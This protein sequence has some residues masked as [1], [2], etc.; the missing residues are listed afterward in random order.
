MSKVISMFEDSEDIYEG[1]E[2]VVGTLQVAAGQ[3]GDHEHKLGEVA[4]QK[5]IQEMDIHY[6][7]GFS[8]PHFSRC[9]DR[10]SEEIQEL[11][12]VLIQDNKFSDVK[13][14]T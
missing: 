1:K 11:D 10:K 4:E 3:H 14:E 13:E 8:I 2:I 6:D 12:A 9:G 5:P 7:A